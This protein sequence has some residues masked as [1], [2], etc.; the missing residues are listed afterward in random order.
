[1]LILIKLFFLFLISIGVVH[2][3]GRI[4]SKRKWYQPIY[5]LSPQTH[6][7][8]IH[9]PAIG[10]VAMIC[11]GVI[12][13]ILFREHLS[14]NVLWLILIMGLF[15]L[16]GFIDDLIAMKS[17]RNKGLSL[18]QKLIIQL[19]FSGISI[20]IYTL[21]IQSIS[22]GEILFYSI[23]MIGASNATNLTDGLDGLLGG[24]MIISL[25]SIMMI[26][27]F[28]FS[29]DTLVFIGIMI[30]VI[31]AFLFFNHYPAKIFMGDTGSL[32][33]GA[34]LVGLAMLYGNIW[35]LLPLGMVYII[36]TVSVMIQV[37]W[38]KRTKTRV[39]LMT[40]LHHHFEKL[41]IQEVH[42]VYI[43]WCMGC[44]GALIG[45]SSQFL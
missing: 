38:Y 41:G 25:V 26:G 37:F 30:T 20:I 3:W 27:W 7:E 19:Y 36:E 6:Q 45:I 39:F 8:K 24:N 12:G 21:Y 44:L 11:S 10:G 5:G 32:P 18:R 14:F 23:V 42:I 2:Q 34:L 33:M 40:P 28:S 16:I 15:A 43:F 29:M 9:T 22:V 17:G 1:M 13:A 35:I 4:A 31:V